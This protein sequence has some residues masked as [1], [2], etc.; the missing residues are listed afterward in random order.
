MPRDGICC[1]QFL[2][3]FSCKSMIPPSLFSK[4]CDILC[5]DYVLGFERSYCPNRN[6]MALVVNE[7]ERKGTLKKAR[8]PNCKRWFCFRCKSNWHAG[9]RCEEIGDLLGDRND[10][11]FGRLVKSKNWV[12]CPGC[13]HCVERRDG[14][15]VMKCRCNTY[16]C[17]KCGGKCPSGC[18]CKE[19]GDIYIHYYQLPTMFA[20]FLQFLVAVLL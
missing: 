3:P 18:L 16:F 15:P 11:L 9:Y 5:E 6:C 17:Y 13:G 4:W 1:E 7:C 10:M 12:R 14:C 2:D 20:L 8:C 19:K